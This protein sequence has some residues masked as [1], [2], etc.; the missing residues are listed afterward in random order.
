[1]DAFYDFL[2]GPGAW[3][4][5]A[6]FLGGL[7]VRAVFL[8]GLSRE[9]DKVFYNHFEW[10]WGIRSIVHWLIPLG[11][12]SLRAQPLFGLVFFVFHAC[13]F[14]VPLFLL[15]HNIM[16]DDAFG[17]SL[18]AMPD[19]L[20]DWLTLVVIACLAFLF[21]RR[22]VRPEVRAISEAWDFILLLLVA[23]P[24][25]TGWLAVNGYG[26]YKLNMVLHVLSGEVMLILVPF[27]KL[28]HIMLFFFT[29]AF[30]GSE[31]GA[32]RQIEGRLGA[33]VW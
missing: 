16:W 20:A 12:V 4:A 22:L 30:L 29:R 21:V 18:W 24:F 11:S 8:Y 17:L 5:F 26:D 14:A 7:V 3:I 1:M 33:K 13:L 6:V 9:R 31:M 19:K 23:A 15:A 10:S 25:V 28:G 27:S 2:T 32:R